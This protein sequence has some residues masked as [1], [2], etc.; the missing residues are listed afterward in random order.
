MPEVNVFINIEPISILGTNAVCILLMNLFNFLWLFKF[1]NSLITTIDTLPKTI[2]SWLNIICNIIIICGI[3]K[4][5]RT[6][7]Y[8]ST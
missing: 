4:I 1:F 7:T 2:V 6:F 3:S 8:R 5:F